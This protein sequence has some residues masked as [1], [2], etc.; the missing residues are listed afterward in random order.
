MENVTPMPGAETAS[1]ANLRDLLARL[2]LVAFDEALAADFGAVARRVA[3]EAAVEAYG[4]LEAIPPGTLAHAGTVLA[5]RCSGPEG[6]ALAALRGLRRRGLRTPALLLLPTAAA[7]SGGA[8]R[9][10]GAIDLLPEEGFT[11]F[12]LQRALVNLWTAQDLEERALD[13]LSRLHES[14]RSRL[15]LRR[16]LTQLSHQLALLE[17]DDELTGWRTAGSVLARME[18]E[19]RRARAYRFPV[20]C[21]L[22]SIDDFQ[23]IRR[24]FDSSFADFALVQIAHRLKRAL[25]SSDLLARYGE[26][27]FV[28]L[29]PF[30]TSQGALGLAERLKHAA[31][32]EPVRRDPHNLEVALSVGLAMLGE[33]MQGARD[34]IAAAAQSAG[35]PVPVELGEVEAA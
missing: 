12:D 2:V 8:Y 14:E 24:R 10:L 19:V 20:A 11:A 23:G 6:S 4:D 3:P 16:H 31:A 27:Q 13:L 28:M 26:H 9:Q 7:A 34:L 25:R 29:S 30:T 21:L 15:H 33:P 1:E 22:L 5:L 17:I 35:K 32:C 18:E